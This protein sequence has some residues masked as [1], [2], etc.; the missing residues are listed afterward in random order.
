MKPVSMKTSFTLPQ[1]EIPLQ[2]YNLMAD[3]PE[4][5]APP[6]PIKLLPAKALRPL[7]SSFQ[8]KG[9]AAMKSMTVPDSSLLTKGRC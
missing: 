3:F 1:S 2:W 6:P 7:S 4:P 9:C 8:S 5:M